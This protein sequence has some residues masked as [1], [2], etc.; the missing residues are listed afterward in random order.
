MKKFIKKLY[1]IL[2]NWYN[3]L[4]FSSCGRNVFIGKSMNVHTFKDAKIILGNNVR[5]GNNARLA[6]YKSGENQAEIFIGD[7]TY[8]GNYLSIITAD[9]VMIGK[10]VLMASHI[11]IMGHNHGINPENMG[12]YGDQ[13][14]V[15]GGVV[16]D[17]EAWIGER[18][19]ILPGVKIGKRA[20][21][22]AGAI[23]TTDIPDYCI[24]VGNPA[25]VIKE[26]NFKKHCW[27][28]ICNE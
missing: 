3:I 9:K 17:D 2:F 10:K 5:L 6:L 28:R 16:I 15:C 14:L 21:V 25:K 4:Q 22:G 18:V 26:Y 11:T 27:E 12:T 1:T 7:N 19:C 20:I 8:I 23:V 13:P 24:A